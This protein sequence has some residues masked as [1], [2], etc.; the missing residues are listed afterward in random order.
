MGARQTAR[1]GLTAVGWFIVAVISLAAITA[2]VLLLRW[3]FAPA[4]GAVQQREQT[5]GS[6]TY[7]IQAYD[8]FH[9][10]CNTARSTQQNIAL[11]RQQLEQATKAGADQGRVMQLQTNVTALQMTLNDEVNQYNSD[12]S[13]ADTRAHFLASDLPYALDATQEIVC[14]R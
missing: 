1:D 12:A 8:A 13:K 2:A 3:T 9:D 11:A 6:G 5:I 4:N 7:R 14:S 10:D